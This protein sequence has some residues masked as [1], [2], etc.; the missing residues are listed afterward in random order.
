MQKWLDPTKRFS[1]RVDNYVRYRPGYPME[2]ITLLRGECGLK[3]DSVVA[4]IGSGTGKLSEL[5]LNAGCQVFGVEPNKEMREAGE[6]MNHP[7]FTSVDASAEETTL[8]GHSVDFIT[9]GQAFHWFDRDR[10][11]AEFLRILKP[12]GPAVIIWNHRRDDTTAFLV[13][14]ERLLGEFGTDYSQAHHRRADKPEVIRAFFG[15]EPR[16]KNF[17]NVQHFDFEGLKG[18]LLSSS[19]APV[20]GHPKYEEMLAELKRI[21]DAHQKDGIVAFEYDTH[22]YY[23]H[24]A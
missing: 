19:Y 12:G 6:R 4:D 9:V 1:N 14:Y 16:F 7:N 23:G 15:I 2:I 3:P 5:F 8:P 17:H 21:F 10:C 13:A 24:L 18:R 22:V 11:R 20:A